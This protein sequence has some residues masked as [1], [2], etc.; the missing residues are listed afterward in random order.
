MA[1]GS[2]VVS[3]SSVF[4]VVGF[5]RFCCS[6]ILLMATMYPIVIPIATTRTAPNPIQRY[7]SGPLL[8]RFS[9]G[10]VSGIY[11]Y[12]GVMAVIEPLVANVCVYEVVMSAATV[13]P[14]IW[15]VGVLLYPLP[16]FVIVYSTTLP[17][18]TV[19][20]MTAP[21]VGQISV[22]PGG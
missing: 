21:V 20:V 5:G 16:P 12:C 3:G 7:F 14:D 10:G 13:L 17:F 15:S 9:V 4:S 2:V 6:L 8:G 1:V 22:L 11:G 18:S 19:A